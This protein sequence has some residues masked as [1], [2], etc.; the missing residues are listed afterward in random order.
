MHAWLD[1]LDDHVRWLAPIDL[2]L[3]YMGITH[4]DCVTLVHRKLCALVFEQCVGFLPSH[5]SAVRRALRF[6]VLIREDLKSKH[7]QNVVIT[8][9]ALSSQSFKNPDGCSGRNLK[10]RRP[11]Q[12]SDVKTTESSEE[13]KS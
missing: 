3:D 5:R 7:L 4:L 10:A 13:L 9:T 12:T 11:A 8:K 6:K 1:D 2:N